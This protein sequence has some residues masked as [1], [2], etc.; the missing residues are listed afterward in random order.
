[1][2][3]SICW[4][5]SLTSSRRTCSQVARSNS[6]VSKGWTNTSQASKSQQVA[7][8]IHRN[9]GLKGTVKQVKKMILMRHLKTPMLACTTKFTGELLMKF[10]KTNLRMRKKIK[11]KSWS[12]N[13]KGK[14]LIKLTHQEQYLTSM[15]P[16]DP[17][18]L[19][20]KSRNQKEI[21]SDSLH[22]SVR[23]VPQ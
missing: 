23:I 15:S 7:L 16:R 3:W 18:L 10:P 2:R 19:G 4:K 11:M 12:P 22:Q 20:N 9:L 5:E 13:K 17:T 21:L 8:R 6:F 14:G 1:M